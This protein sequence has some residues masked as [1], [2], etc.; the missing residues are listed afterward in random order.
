M[1][2][3][4]YNLFEDI[5]HEKNTAWD[6]TV[7]KQPNPFNHKETHPAEMGLQRRKA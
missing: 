7:P 4:I 3:F 2:V 1:T 6:A 5:H